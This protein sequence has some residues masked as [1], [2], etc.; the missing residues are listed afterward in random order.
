MLPVRR[1]FLPFWVAWNKCDV[2][3]VE[4]DC[5]GCGPRAVNVIFYL[6]EMKLGELSKNRDVDLW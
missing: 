1:Q 4:V 6:D 5:V 3:G 2:G